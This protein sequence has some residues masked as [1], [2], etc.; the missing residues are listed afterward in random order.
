MAGRLAAP[1]MRVRFRGV[2][3]ETAGTRSA[4]RGGL[5]PRNPLSEPPRCRAL[6]RRPY[7][8]LQAADR[9][10]CR[11][12]GRIGAPRGRPVR[13]KPAVFTAGAARPSHDAPVDTDPPA[14]GGERRITED[15]APGISLCILCAKRDPS[16][17]GKIS[18]GGRAASS[19]RPP[20]RRR[21]RAAACRR[22][23]HRAPRRPSPARRYPRR[24]PAPDARGS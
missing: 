1:G 24:A 23:G 17:R 16:G 14:K 2:R 18:P 6:S 12:G 10:W 21:R 9:S 7:G 15:S 11:S 19:G 8:R 20:T 3:K 22:G 4:P 13:E 5:S